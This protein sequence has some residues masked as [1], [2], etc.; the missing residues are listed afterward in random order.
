VWA[1]GSIVT[2][3]AYP[4]LSRRLGR[5]RIF[6]AAAA[7]MSLGAL[8]FVVGYH[9]GVTLLAATLLR[10]AGSA[11]LTGTTATLADERG[12]SGRS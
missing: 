3:L 2:G 1:S 7:A 11:L 4:R 5:R 10:L 6:W 8:L 9:L 12:A